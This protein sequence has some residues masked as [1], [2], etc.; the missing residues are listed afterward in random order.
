MMNQSHHGPQAPA[1]QWDRLAIVVDKST[2][3]QTARFYQL[4]PG[5]LEWQENLPQTS[6][7]V[8]CF[9]CHSNGPRALRPVDEKGP[10]SLSWNDKAK[11]FWWNLKIKT[12]GRIQ[13]DPAHDQED[14]GRAVPFRRQGAYENEE[15]QVA[16]CI[17]CHRETGWLARGALR[18]QNFMSIRFMTE[19][20]AMPPPGFSMSEGERRKLKLFL[21]G[22]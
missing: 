17:R 15:L 1:E 12:Y 13:P 22:F 2:Q 19:S 10:A 11:I 4:Q 16:T 3:S 8:S 14:R 6:F 18:R 9:M 7:R 21:D 20:G 5:K